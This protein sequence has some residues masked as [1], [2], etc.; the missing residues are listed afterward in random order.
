ML[1]DPRHTP[2]LRQWWLRSSDPRKMEFLGEFREAACPDNVEGIPYPQVREQIF[3]V[4]TQVYGLTNVAVIEKWFLERKTVN[5]RVLH[6]V[7]HPAIILRDALTNQ[8]LAEEYAFNGKMTARSTYRNP[9]RRVI[10]PIP[11]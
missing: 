7:D 3:I 6:G 11:R 5:K 2:L 1:V 4:E 10:H 9:E 8:T